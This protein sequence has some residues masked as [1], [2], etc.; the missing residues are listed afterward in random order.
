[1]VL[2]LSLPAVV[3]I[4]EYPPAYCFSQKTGLILVKINKDLK[5]KS[6]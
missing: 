4:P 3:K 2:I 6:H 5:A 1:M